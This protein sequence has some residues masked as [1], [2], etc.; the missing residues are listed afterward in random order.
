MRIM[1]KTT[2]ILWAAAALL[3]LW[4]I[5]DFYHCAVTGREVLRYY[6]GAEAIRQLVRYSLI[7]GV[8]KVLVGLLLILAARLRRHRNREP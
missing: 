4:G 6:D 7:Q 3:L 2:W 8:V 5:V 1:K